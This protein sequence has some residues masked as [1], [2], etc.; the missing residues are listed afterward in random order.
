M[1]RG[2]LVLRECSN[3]E[4]PYKTITI[5]K[6]CVLHIADEVLKLSEGHIISIFLRMHFILLPF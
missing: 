4:R 1:Y 3:L 2:F 5:F 6:L